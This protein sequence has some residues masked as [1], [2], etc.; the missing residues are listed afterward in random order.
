MPAVEHLPP[1]E[2]PFLAAI[3]WYDRNLDGLRPEEMLSRYEAG[4][5]FRGV[6]CD[7]SPEER[8]WIRYLVKRYGSTIDP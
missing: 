2:L 3:S 5:R 6:L 4:W 7:P 1:R 8:E